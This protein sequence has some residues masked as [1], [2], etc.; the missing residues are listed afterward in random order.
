MFDEEGHVTMWGR[1]GIYRSAA[2]AP[3]AANFLL[4]HSEANP[5]LAR[6]IA[7]G[8]VLQFAT[9]KNASMKECHALASMA[10][11]NH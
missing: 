1:S 10:H 5:G 6:R 8:A 7:S 4:K 9:E 11:S 2:S 3:L